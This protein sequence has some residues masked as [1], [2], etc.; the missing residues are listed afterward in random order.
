MKC[1]RKIH[2]DEMFY[3][4]EISDSQTSHFEFVQE[5]QLNVSKH[6]KVSD[7]LHSKKNT[8]RACLPLFIGTLT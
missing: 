7:N 4:R 2:S 5:R 1:S 6:F 8:S 3:N